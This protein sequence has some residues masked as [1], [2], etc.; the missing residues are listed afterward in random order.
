MQLA[1]IWEEIM[2]RFPEIRIVGEPIRTYSNFVH[3]FETMP[4]VIPARA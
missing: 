3:G 4:V 2:K 1:I